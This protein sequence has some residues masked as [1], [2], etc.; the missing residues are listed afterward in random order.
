M[1]MGTEWSQSQA[2]LRTPWRFWKTQFCPGSILS[3]QIFSLSIPA[4][5]I[6]YATESFLEQ[7]PSMHWYGTACQHPDARTV[8][9]WP[10]LKSK[11]GEKKKS[12]SDN[13]TVMLNSLTWSIFFYLFVLAMGTGRDV[14]QGDTRTSTRILMFVLQQLLMVEA[15]SAYLTDTQQVGSWQVFLLYIHTRPNLWEQQA[16]RVS[17]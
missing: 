15:E 5:R 12:I 11:W 13:G 3:K 9:C 2:S 4:L 14:F 16:F 1:L 10:V 17:E 6:S 8:S 7:S